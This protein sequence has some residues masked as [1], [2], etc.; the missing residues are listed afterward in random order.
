M[1]IGSN[2]ALMRGIEGTRCAAKAWHEENTPTYLTP[3]VGQ[4]GHPAFC[5]RFF[6]YT[7][8]WLGW[9]SICQIQVGN[10]STDQLI[11]F[12][13]LSRVF[14]SIE[15]TCMLFAFFP[16]NTLPHLPYYPL[17][18]LS[19]F[20]YINVCKHTHTYMHTFFFLVHL[21]LNPQQYPIVPKLVRVS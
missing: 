2:Q 21:R 8:T 17:S 12:N 14:S 7:A 4:C 20:L 16:Q 13:F 10:L 1:S 18:L 5:I 3:F 15:V 9:R 11:R 6:L 19:L